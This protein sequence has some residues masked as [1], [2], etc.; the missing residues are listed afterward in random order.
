MVAFVFQ[1]LTWARPSRWT[2]QPEVL[3]QSGPFCPSVSLPI[4]T[5]SCWRGLLLFICAKSTLECRDRTRT[6]NSVVRRAKWREE[7]DLLSVEFTVSFRSLVLL[8][9]AAA[10]GYLMWRNWRLKNQKSMNFDNPVYL[11][12]TEEDL[13]IDITRHGASV[14]HTYPAVSV[15]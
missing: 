11:K 5:Q 8:A 9:M 15:V 10:G 14:G 13:N 12:T 2:P 1:K 6:D 7:S 4:H 3:L